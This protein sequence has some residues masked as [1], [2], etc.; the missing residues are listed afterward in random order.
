M[1]WKKGMKWIVAVFAALV[2]MSVFVGA[3]SGA[4]SITISKLSANPDKPVI[5]AGLSSVTVRFD[6]EIKGGFDSAEISFGDKSNVISITQN[7]GQP[8][9]HT[10]YST[11]TFNV[12]LTAKN[13]DRS[14]EKKLALTITNEK[15]AASFSADTLSG[16]APL[17]VKF[18]DISTGTL[19]KV[20]HRSWE[21]GDGSAASSQKSVT[22]RFEK[23]GTYYVK[24]FISDG[25]NQ[26]T[27]T[28]TITVTKNGDK[29]PAKIDVDYEPFIIIGDVGVPSPFDLI[30]EFVRL[31]QAM[32]NF[33]NY[34]IF[35]GENSES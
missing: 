9:A 22:H 18:D 12:V 28:K 26:D 25:I 4:D 19:G 1:N 7:K 34:T 24:L 3:V 2:L 6:Y 31:I 5:L 15:F 14:V 11:G 30:A 21:F 33:D 17:T 13:E 35:S 16:E 27:A 32:L 29:E 8:L 23:E 20:I 10:Y